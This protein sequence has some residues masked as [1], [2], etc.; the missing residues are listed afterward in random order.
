MKWLLVIVGIVAGI[1]LAAALIGAALPKEHRVTRQASYRQAPEVIW[2]AISDYGKFPEWRKTVARVEPLASP[3]G[4]PAWREFDSRGE[5]IPYEVV[6]ATPP[7]H[8]VT[9][10]ADPKLPYGGTWTFEILPAAGGSVLR[11]T[12]NGEVRNWIFRFMA[13]FV[14]GSRATLDMYLKALGQKFGENVAI[15]D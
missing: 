12:E 10:I 11:I 14:F 3:N 15:K 2:Q 8:L 9:R 4:P 5:A 13:R 6:E 7:S 1:V